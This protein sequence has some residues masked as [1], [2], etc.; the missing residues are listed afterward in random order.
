[1]SEWMLF[2]LLCAAAPLLSLVVRRLRPGWSPLR[3]SL[4]AAVPVPGAL[5]LLCAFVYA[6]SA[7]ATPEQCG[8]D[9]CGMA[10][11]AALIVAAF[12]VVSLIVG[13]GLA[14]ALQYGLARR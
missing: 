4:W 11:M 14:L 2:L 9:A 8:V 5:L 7:L 3:T 6:S 10:M 13:W 12:A 1:M